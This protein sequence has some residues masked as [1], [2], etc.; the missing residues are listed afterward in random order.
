MLDTC[1]RH[2]FERAED[3][4]RS[5]GNGFCGDCLVYAFGPKRPPY[6]IGC[7]IAAAGVRSTAGNR[8]ATRKELRAAAKERRARRRG[9]GGDHVQVAE[10]LASAIAEEPVRPSIEETA[11]DPAGD[12]SWVPVGAVAH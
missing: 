5:C 10:A 7:A 9:K 11:I 2:P 3:T 8:P 12:H 4:C 1:T 6:C